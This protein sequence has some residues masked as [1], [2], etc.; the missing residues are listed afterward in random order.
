MRTLEQAQYYPNTHGQPHLNSHPPALLNR[1]GQGLVE[2]IILVALV[3]VSAIGITRLLGQTISGQF[4]NI[5]NSLQGN[6]RKA[7]LDPV[8]EGA[9]R[10]RDL[11]DFMEGAAKD[12]K[13]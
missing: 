8:H 4:A 6:E 1:R 10:R 2:Y 5:T 13:Q 9:Y 12:A 7:R 3:A 11:S